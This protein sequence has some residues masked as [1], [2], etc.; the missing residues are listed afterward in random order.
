[1]LTILD[2]AGRTCEGIS[3][4]QLLQ[5]GGAGLLGLSLPKVLSAENAL[6]VH[7]GRARSV[8]FL[9][10]FGGPSQLETFDMKPRAPSNIRGPFRPI[11]S[12]TPGLLISEHLPRLANISDKFC[13]LRTL[14]HTF[15]DHSGGGHYIQTGKRWHIPIGGGFDATPSDWPSMGSVVEYLNQRQ[16]GPGSLPRYAVVP[17]YLGRLEQAGQYRRPGEYGGWLGRAYNP[18]TTTVNKRNLQDNPYWRACTDE[19]L[20]FQIEGSAPPA[21]VT[22]DRVRGRQSLLEQFDGQRRLLDGLRRPGELDRVRQRALALVTSNRTRRALNIRLEPDRVRNSYGRHLFGQSTLMAR[23]LIEAGVR[24]VT[25]HYE[26]IDGYSWDSHVHSNDV[27][28]HLLPTFDQALAALLIDL[29]QRGLLSETLVVA[30]GEMGRTPTGNAQGGRGH[31]STLFPA[32]LAGAGIRGGTMYGASDKDAA[33]PIDHP[34]T[35]EDLA[36]TIYDALGIDPEMR[37]QDA[38]GRPVPVVDGG[39]PVRAIFG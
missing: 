1:M 26:A 39:R 29:D 6:P 9:F 5:A 12:R 23:R 19:E 8:I 18:L 28:N 36:A 33:Y 22:L 30:L 13:V 27:K 16:N 24:F 3:R 21:E 34:T 37:L 10:L 20:T 11:A 15:N 17:N 35:P 14:T 32:V 25:V 4:R 2:R 38:L 7:G 31:W